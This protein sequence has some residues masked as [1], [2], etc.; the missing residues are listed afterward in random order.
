ML[1]YNMFLLQLQRLSTEMD[2]MCQIGK[3]LL[4]SRSKMPRTKQ[5]LL[6]V[7]R[8]FIL[9]L[10]E[11]ISKMSVSNCIFT[12]NMYVCSNIPTPTHMDITFSSWHSVVR[13]VK[14][15]WHCALYEQLPFI[16]RL[17]SYELFTNGKNEASLYR[18]WFALMRCPLR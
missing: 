13:I 12:Y 15:T 7:Q 8:V 3:T 5:S 17:K 2:N 10:T 11:F 1:F 6:Y 4:V 18:Q 9:V 14:E 16:Y